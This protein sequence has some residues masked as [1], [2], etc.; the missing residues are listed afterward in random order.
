V[1]ERADVGVRTAT[2]L[3]LLINVAATL[4]RLYRLTTWQHFFGDEGREM[5]A[6]EQMLT[7]GVFPLIGPPLAGHPQHLGPFF[8]FLMAPA[9]WVAN[10]QPIGPATLI[11]LCG[12]ATVL[13]IYQFCNDFF[14]SRLAG[15]VAATGYATS[16]VA[17]YHSRYVWNPNMAPL[18]VVA[19]LYCLCATIRSRQRFLPWLGLTLSIATQLQP[20]LIIALPA[21]VVIWLLYQPRVTNLWLYPL[22][23]LLFMVAEVPLL[24]FE[25][26]TGF[27]NTHGW[28]DTFLGRKADGTAAPASGGLLSRL[29]HGL[30]RSAQELWQFFGRILGL[31]PAGYLLVLAALLAGCGLV[32]LVTAL[33]DRRTTPGVAA[34]VI[35]LWATNFFL[36]F[37]IYPGPIYEQ[38]FVALFPLPFLMLGLTA[39]R[40]WWSGWGIIGQLA[41]VACVLALAGSNVNGLWKYHFGLKPFQM[42]ADQFGGIQAAG[43]TI[44]DM[45]QVVDYIAEKTRGHSFNLVLAAADD[46]DMGYRYLLHLKGLTPS[47]NRQATL[48]QL[49]SNDPAIHYPGTARNYFLIVQPKWRP[50]SAWPSWTLNVNPINNLVYPDRPFRYVLVR[51]IQQNWAPRTVSRAYDELPC[52]E[53]QIPPLLQC[54]SINN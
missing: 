51:F 41:V 52:D 32:L 18:F 40:L 34:G 11:A 13:L 9:V 14:E 33:R 44:T 30:N 19:V 3:L 23:F 5:F 12:V 8:Y 20:V 15:L 54:D 38:Y 16:Q 22:A 45:Q 39:H 25:W 37:G 26:M 48:S 7:K 6:V 36:G 43:M 42:D 46:H 50:Q 53:G 35:V 31:D 24:I 49:K 4:L 17:V 27:R 10:Y 47:R 2:V 29:E 1:V 21:V 28:I